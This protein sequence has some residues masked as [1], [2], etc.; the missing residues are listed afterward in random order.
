MN[1]PRRATVLVSILGAVAVAAY[2]VWGALQIIVLTPLA[3]V[4]GR[5]LAEIRGG[6][7]AAGESPSDAG[8]VMFLVLG[9]VIAAV[10]AVLVI[11]TSADPQLAALLFLAVLT[12]GA[13]A[14]FIAS[15]GPGMSLSDTYFVSGGVTLPGVAPLYVVSVAAAL[16]CVV[17]GA[18]VSGRSRPA[19]VT[20]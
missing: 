12:L 2:A 15:F 6:M 13:P 14:L 17:L 11:R 7:A 1:E 4:P 8:P 16:G 3:A 10:V 5:S 9:V 20:I 18:I 19:R